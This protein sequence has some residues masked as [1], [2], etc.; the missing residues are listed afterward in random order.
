MLSK[1]RQQ[2]G[3]QFYRCRLLF[4]TLTH[5][6]AGLSE[7]FNF[8]DKFL[9]FL[10][11]G[12]CEE[13][14]DKRF[15]RVTLVCILKSSDRSTRNKLRVKLLFPPFGF[16]KEGKEFVSNVL[17]TSSAEFPQYSY[18]FILIKLQRHTGPS[19]S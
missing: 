5:G 13:C 17:E 7:T 14:T 11:L 10:L 6:D 18:E 1:G 12:T 2:G 8:H 19:E 3:V 9:T 16:T 4:W 15:D